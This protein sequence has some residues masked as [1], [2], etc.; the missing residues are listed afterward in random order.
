MKN[1]VKK[2]LFLGAHLDDIELGCGGL[3]AKLQ[4]NSNNTIKLLTLSHFNKDSNGKTIIDRDINEAY[5]AI[6]K[7]GL[8]KNQ[9]IIEEIPAQ[10]FEK[11]SQEIR[12]ILLKYRKEYSPDVIFFPSKN[13]IHQD[14]QI[15]YN[16]GQRIFRDK[17]CLGYELIRSTYHLIPNCYIALDKDEINRKVEAVGCYKSQLIQS[18]G[19]YFSK[20]TIISNAIFR[21]KQFNKAYAEA[22][23]IYYCNI[24]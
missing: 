22:F 23:E 5:K 14:H 24:D 17:I 21:G 15:V 4:K 18:A 6:S 11:Y 1:N 13:D 3:I 7:L 12:E 20:E 16:E 19:Y 9:I 10:L 2:Y 8:E